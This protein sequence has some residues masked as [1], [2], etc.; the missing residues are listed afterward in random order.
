VNV[1]YKPIRSY[2]CKDWQAMRNSKAVYSEIIASLRINDSDD[3]K[4]AIVCCLMEDLL[5]VSVPGIMSGKLLEM[6][7]VM[8]ELLSKAISRINSG[9]PVQYVTNSSHFFGRKYFV[10]KN[11]LI[12]RPETEELVQHVLDYLKSLPDGNACR[13]LDIGTGSG[14]IPITISLES[15]ANVFATD[16]S[17]TALAVAQRNANTHRANVIFFHHD[18][19]MESLPVDEFQ[20]IISNPPY[21]AATEK[22]SMRENVLKHE[23]H[24]ALFVPDENP[25][26]FYERISAQAH[27]ALSENGLLIFEINERF[28]QEVATLISRA[29]FREVTIVKDISGKDRIVKGIQPK[30]L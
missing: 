5:G 12:P 9:E 4:N 20:V 7:P 13:I 27:A 18:I 23:P 15:N 22:D 19:L 2:V 24:L 10:D 16:V 6:T 8:Q 17:P 25:L 14:C 30:K 21:I 1:V 26:I 28:G 3:E 29:G 11:V